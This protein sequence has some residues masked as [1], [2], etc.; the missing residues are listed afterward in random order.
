MTNSASQ[1]ILV[2]GASSGIGNH[3]TYYL[4][5]RYHLVYATVRKDE[6]L[7]AL[8][9]IQNVLPI[10]L[11]VQNSNHITAALKLI[12]MKGKGL[13]GLVNNAGIG[14]LGMF[15]TWTDE[16]IFEIFD[17]NVFGP[18]RMINA[19]VRMLIESKGKIVNIGSQGG[20]IT[21][22]YFGP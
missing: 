8:A 18:H 13:Y 19:F 10:Q 15:N 9:Q 22:K 17:I 4:A 16:E 14:G 11:D 6:D 7:A 1:P 21:S 20:M 5:E 12:T 3:L 2:T